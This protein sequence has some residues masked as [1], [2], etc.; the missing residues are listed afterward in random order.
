MEIGNDFL[1]VNFGCGKFSYKI[2]AVQKLNIPEN[3]HT[4]RLE[5]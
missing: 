2:N 3:T 4:N 5:N 1:I